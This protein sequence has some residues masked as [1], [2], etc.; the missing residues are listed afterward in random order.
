MV[1]SFSSRH[2][3]CKIVMKG[4][5]RRWQDLTESLDV[6]TVNAMIMG[7]PQLD[8][9]YIIGNNFI[10]ILLGLS[11]LNLGFLILCCR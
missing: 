7:P 10:D 3:T 11:Y 1:K 5:R 9:T 8:M 4:F 2:T 6:E